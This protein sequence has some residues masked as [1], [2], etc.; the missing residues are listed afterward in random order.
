MKDTLNGIR[1]LGAMIGDKTGVA[2]VSE[3]SEAKRTTEQRNSVNYIH[4]NNI[5]HLEKSHQRFN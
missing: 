4:K 2:M 5:R 3:H 1:G